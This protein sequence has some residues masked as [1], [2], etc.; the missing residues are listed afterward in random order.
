MGWGLN[1]HFIIIEKMFTDLDSFFQ[2]L[3]IN[4]TLMPSLGMNPEHQIFYYNVTPALIGTPSQ[5][6]SIPVWSI[7]FLILKF[8]HIADHSQP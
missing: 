7:L 5:K 6:K 3:L 2:N 4:K 8:F 1:T